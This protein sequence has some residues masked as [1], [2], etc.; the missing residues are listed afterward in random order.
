[1]SDIKVELV[2]ALAEEQWLT[3]VTIAHGSCVADVITASGVRQRYPNVDIDALET[4]VWARLVDRQHPV[5]DGDRVELYRELLI[6]PRE[7]R[8]QLALAG[9]TMSGGAET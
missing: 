3:P 9:Q 2:I 7:A 1:M 5:K 4:G 6:D 8:R